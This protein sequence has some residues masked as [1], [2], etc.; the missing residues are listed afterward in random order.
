MSA[1]EMLQ[2]FIGLTVT[3]VDAEQ[4]FEFVTVTVY[5]DGVVGLTVR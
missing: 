2:Q 1:I 3:L 5:V 4:L